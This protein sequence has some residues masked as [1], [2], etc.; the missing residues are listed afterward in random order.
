MLSLRNS[1]LHHELLLKRNLVKSILGRA[2]LLTP[3][4]RWGT[5]RL[6]PESFLEKSGG[7]GLT[8]AAGRQR[9]ERELL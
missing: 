8:R 7:E 5:E 4:D 6:V 1:Q 2:W 9:L 3:E